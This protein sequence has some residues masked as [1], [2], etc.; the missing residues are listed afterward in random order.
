MSCKVLSSPYHSP[1]VQFSVRASVLNSAKILQ[2]ATTNASAY[3]LVCVNDLI[4]S[5]DLRSVGR[6]L[7]NEKIGRIR[8][9]NFADLLILDGNPLENI[10]I[11]DRPEDHLLGLITGGRVVASRIASLK[12]EV[13]L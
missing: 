9:G 2:H 13:L 4:H 3:A 1:S 5:R 12:T 6:M 8:P 11:L 7:K 10:T